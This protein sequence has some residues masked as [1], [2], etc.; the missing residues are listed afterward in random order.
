MHEE[1]ELQ[2]VSVEYEQQKVWAEKESD[3]AVVG[4]LVAASL[5]AAWWVAACA[6]L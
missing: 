6:S 5:C 4:D 3:R 1:S 2:S